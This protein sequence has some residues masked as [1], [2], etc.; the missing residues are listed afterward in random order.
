MSEIKP[1]TD[2]E[3]ERFREWT[4]YARVAVTGDLPRRILARLDAERARAEKAERE[5]DAVTA[6]ALE[7][8]G[9]VA[10]VEADAANARHVVR[11]LRERLLKQDALL[12]Q[13]P[14]AL[15]AAF[16][17]GVEEREGGSARRQTKFLEPVEVL[18]AAI[19]NHASEGG[20]HE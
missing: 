4:Q 20:Q 2:A 17:A 9:M 16:N 11:R 15:S 13:V 7:W 3:I 12:K 1:A 19:A 18:R 14:G 6:E 5:R 10:A 8:R